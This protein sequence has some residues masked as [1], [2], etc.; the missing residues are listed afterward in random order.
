MLEKVLTF[1]IGWFDQDENTSAAI[2]ARLA[3]E[4]NMVRSCR[5]SGS[6]ATSGLYWS[7]A[8]LCVSFGCRMEVS[9]CD[10]SY[11][12]FS[13]LLFLFKERVD[14]ANVRKSPNSTK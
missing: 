7:F 12:T 10:D 2:Y 13:H 6:N 5:R 3:T 9:P 11:A 14:E 1:E 4:A 8:C